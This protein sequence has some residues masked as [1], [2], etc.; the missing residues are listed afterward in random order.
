MVTFQ[1]SKYTDIDSNELWGSVSIKI[2]GAM[3][4][5]YY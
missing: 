5:K 3:Y 4:L 2:F 1:Q